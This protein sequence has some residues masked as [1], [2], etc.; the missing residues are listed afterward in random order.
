MVAL[1]TVAF[2]LLRGPAWSLGGDGLAGGWAELPGILQRSP[3]LPQGLR[4]RKGSGFPQGP[5]LRSDQLGSRH[6]GTRP[7]TLDSRFRI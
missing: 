1:D 5:P 4:S 7:P 3:P 6:Q 2:A